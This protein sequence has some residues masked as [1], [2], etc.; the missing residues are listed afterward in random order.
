MNQDNHDKP[1][2]DF[3]TPEEMDFPKYKDAPARR[4]PLYD[5]RLTTPLHT[6]APNRNEKQILQLT[7]THRSLINRQD[8]E[9]QTPTHIAAAC[10]NLEAINIFFNIG[11]AN[12]MVRDQNGKTPRQLAEEARHVYAAHL[13]EGFEQI[14]AY[15]QAPFL[16]A[17]KAVESKDNNLVHENGNADRTP[18]FELCLLPGRS[19]LLEKLLARGADINHVDAF[20]CTPLHVA[21]QHDNTEAVGILLA[22]G[23]KKD[24]EDKF[25]MMPFGYMAKAPNVKELYGEQ[26]KLSSQRR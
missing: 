5:G 9:G 17:E 1:M 6:V 3:L 4:R 16:H 22:H 15:K 19:D 13:L 18:I 11:G 24:V 8:D 25:G 12:P 20:G 14:Y 23:A 7:S 2:S 26:L 21:V 10:G